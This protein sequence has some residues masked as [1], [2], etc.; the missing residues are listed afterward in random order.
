MKLLKISGSSSFVKNTCLLMFGG[1]EMM[2]QISIVLQYLKCIIPL[3][4]QH[5]IMLL[6]QW[7]C[8]RNRLHI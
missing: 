5:V 7:C 2:E 1:A 3:P 4:R 8:L 6:I